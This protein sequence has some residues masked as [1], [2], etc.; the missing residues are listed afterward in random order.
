M[1]HEQAVDAVVD[2]KRNAAH[3]QDSLFG[4][5]TEAAETLTVEVPEQEWETGTLLAFEREMLGLYV[6]SHPLD[7]AEPV[8]EAHRDTTIADLLA[9]PR[10]DAPVRV[11]GIISTVQRKVTKQGTPGRSSPWRTTTPPSS[12][13]SSPRPTRSMG[14]R[15]PKTA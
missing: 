2:L 11:A 7:G 13:S 9:S 8:L 5:S 6:S 12:A 3:G 1:V 10:A 14:R 4:A 15:L